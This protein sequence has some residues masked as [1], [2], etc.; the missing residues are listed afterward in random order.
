MLPPALADCTPERYAQMRG[1]GAPRRVFGFG[2]GTADDLAGRRRSA[3]S[4]GRQRGRACRDEPARPAGSAGF[5]LST[6]VCREFR[7]DG[8]RHPDWLED[9]VARRPE[10][11]EALT[12]SRFGG[13][14]APLL[15]AVRSG[16]AV[17]MP[18]MMDTVLNLGLNDV[19]VMGL[20]ARSGDSRFAWDTYRRFIQMY[21]AVVMGID[22]DRFEQIL[23]FGETAHAAAGWTAI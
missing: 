22:H 23:E 17:S 10:W 2:G 21:G 20:A 19:T 18:G 3:G 14:A 9:Q 8:G 4:A 16:A 7:Q 13:A 1:G 12:D 6:P 11:V 5:T 15:V